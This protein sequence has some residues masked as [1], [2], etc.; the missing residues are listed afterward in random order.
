MAMTVER[1]IAMAGA[2]QE[3]VDHDGSLP[4][5]TAAHYFSFAAVAL[6]AERDA[7]LGALADAGIT[8][9]PIYV[10]VCEALRRLRERADGRP[11]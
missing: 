4:A 9:G 8:D 7:A 6:A 1:I 2:W 10:R 5:D 11:R 3:A